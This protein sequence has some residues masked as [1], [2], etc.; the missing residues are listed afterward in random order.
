MKDE[1]GKAFD[2]GG[3]AQEGDQGAGDAVD[4]EHLAEPEPPAEQRDAAAQQEPP[5]RRSQ[6]DAGQDEQ[7]VESRIAAAQIQLEEGVDTIKCEESLALFPQCL[8]S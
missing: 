6:E 1:T 2:Q 3:Q 7:H 5:G 8:G 4:D